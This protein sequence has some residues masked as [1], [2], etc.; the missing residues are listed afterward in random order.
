MR[1]LPISTLRSYRQPS[2]AYDIH[3]LNYHPNSFDA[4]LAKEGAEVRRAIIVMY[5]AEAPRRRHSAFVNAR[6]KR[7]NLK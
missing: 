3:M 1:N 7:K 5:S 2:R 4:Y 6:N